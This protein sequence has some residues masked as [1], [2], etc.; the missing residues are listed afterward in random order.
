LSVTELVAESVVLVVGVGRSPAGFLDFVF[1]GGGSL[2]EKADSGEGGGT[3]MVGV[4]AG[5]W[6]VIQVSVLERTGS[7]GKVCEGFLGGNVVANWERFVVEGLSGKAGKLD[8]V[9]VWCVFV[10]IDQEGVLSWKDN[11][12]RFGGDE[13][14]EAL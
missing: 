13:V 2:F 7:L 9:R 6:G 14:D 11:V 4:K 10:V 3:K 12:E 1:K 5:E 8:V